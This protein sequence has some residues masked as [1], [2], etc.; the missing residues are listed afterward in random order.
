LT[1]TGHAIVL[2]DIQNIISRIS[3]I[4][5]AM[6]GKT[7]IL[8]GGAGFL[9]S[10]MVAVIQ[11]MNAKFFAQ[12]CRLIV[13]DNYITGS[14]KNKLIDITDP[15]ICFVEHN[16][17]LPFETEGAVDFIIHAAGIAS[18]VY[19]KSFPIEA[20]ESTIWGAKNLLELAKKKQSESYLF[21]SSSEIYGDP[22][23]RF[24]PTPETYKGN[25][26]CTGP[27]A[28]Y[29]E[30]KRLGE[31][32]SMTYYHRFQIPVKAVRPFNIY[33]PGMKTDDYRVI[34]NFLMRALTNRPLPI[35]G[36]GDQ[37]RT[38]CYVTDA[39]TGFFKVLLSKQN[40]EVY[41]VGNDQEEIS[42]IG[43]AKTISELFEQKPALDYIGYPENYPKDE[44]H[45]RA[46]DLSKIK[47]S[48]QYVPLVDLRSGLRRTLTW[49]RELV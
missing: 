32:M 4:A 12:P 10:Y 11:E 3:D 20:I 5:P 2:E 41:N 14:R 24:I 26:S 21:F 22:D 23:P 28:C 1:S 29:D 34:P 49:F 25:V 31:T 17:S 19:Y 43:L 48:L 15:N 39:V 47:Q 42:M 9:G 38:F 33:G 37:T 27:R 45:R 44:P 46:P 7:L 35:H 18:P 30:S 16:V 36:S 13:L 8:S 6:E 40:G